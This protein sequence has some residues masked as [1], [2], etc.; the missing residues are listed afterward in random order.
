[1]AWGLVLAYLVPAAI[2][3][4]RAPRVPYA[5]GWRFLGYFVQQRF[6]RDVF[7]V[8]NGHFEVIPNL[9]RVLDLRL[10][11][12]GQGLQVIAG[13]LLLAAS[14]LVAWRCVRELPRPGTRVAAMLVVVLGLCWLGNMRVLAHANESVHAYAITLAL[15]L[16]I[17]ALTRRAGPVRIQDAIAAATCGLAAALSFGSGIA[18]FPALLVVALLRHANW[19]VL[20]IL[21]GSGLAAFV[22]LRAAGAGA[23][24]GW[25]P[26]RQIDL[27]SRWLAGPWL[28]AAWPALDPAIAERIPVAGARSMLM[29]MARGWQAIFG[30]AT[31]AR[32]PHA[33]VGALGIVALA[34]LSL[35]SWRRGDEA[36]TRL[37]GLGL[38]WFA[39]GVGAMVAIVRSGYFDAYPEQLLAP[40]Y[41]VW[42]SLFWAGLGLAMVSRA[43]REGRALVIAVLVAMALLPSQLWMSRLAESMRTTAAQTAVAVAVGVLEPGWPT[44][45]SVPA[46]ISAVRPALRVARAAVFAWPETTTLDR[47][48]P[49]TAHDVPASGWTLEPAANLFGAPGRRVRLHAIAPGVPRLL[50]ID[51]DGVVRG[52]AIRD[53]E[54][55]PDAWLGWTGDARADAIRAASL[56]PP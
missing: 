27:A 18:V 2:V 34:I 19:R 45:E 38:A 25:M 11:D 51:G 49:M 29:P 10:F 50:L 5:D 41:V 52:L 22:L 37:I 14:L 42:S 13:M 23:M 7:M 39:L 12:A 17:G 53:P 43:R 15:L 48:L 36:C 26:L 47:P 54:A 6:P 8:D 9:V 35:R 24:P 28:Y 3:M 1:M 21:I 32:W 31:L 44:G 33:A 4:W 56:P 40:R 46:E 16:G 55:G 30:P 20:A